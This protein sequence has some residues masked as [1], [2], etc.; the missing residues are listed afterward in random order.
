MIIGCIEFCA[1]VQKVFVCFAI[2]VIIHIVARF[3][4]GR[5]RGAEPTLCAGTGPLAIAAAKTI[6]CFACTSGQAE[7][8]IHDTI[9]VVIHTVAFFWLCCSGCAALPSTVAITDF[10]S[11]AAAAS[12][13]DGTRSGGAVICGVAGAATACGCASPYALAKL[14]TGVV[15]SA[16]AA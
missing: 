4:D 7:V 13:G 11:I 6:S 8:F 1:G 10:C 9:A 16:V 15:C 12:I 2:T 5:G 3:C 14:L